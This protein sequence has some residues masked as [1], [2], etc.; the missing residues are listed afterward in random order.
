MSSVQVSGPTFRFY[1]IARFAGETRCY[2]W[3]HGADGEILSCDLYGHRQ[4][5]EVA[6]WLERRH[7]D[8]PRVDYRQSFCPRQV[9]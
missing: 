8:L 2:V 3:E 6:T 9:A 5:R 1:S 7:P 4:A